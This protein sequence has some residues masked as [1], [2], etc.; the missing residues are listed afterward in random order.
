MRIA[1]QKQNTAR[2]GNAIIEFALSATLLFTM[3]FGTFQ[4][5]YTFYVYNQLQAAI[6]SGVRYAS[7]R[8]YTLQGTS[9]PEKIASAVKN[10]VVYGEPDPAHS[11]LPI[12]K[13][14]S[15]SKV[16][17]TYALDAAG[18]PTDVTVKVNTFTIDAVVKTFTFSNKPYANIPFFGRYA[19]AENCD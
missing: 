14:L 15:T 18:V 9:C 12:V 2:R 1:L 3:L 5:G 19:P 6:R 11:V 8:P 16:D 10:V 13:G 7:L 17:V 4:F